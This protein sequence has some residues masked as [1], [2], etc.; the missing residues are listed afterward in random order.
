MPR[1]VLVG[2]FALPTGLATQLQLQ[3]QYGSSIMFKAKKE[4][5]NL[6]PQGRIGRKDVIEAQHVSF[7]QSMIGVR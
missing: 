2:T 7:T 5:K 6:R 4:R 1:L 3:L